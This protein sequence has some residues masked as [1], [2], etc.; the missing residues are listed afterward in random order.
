MCIRDRNSSALLAIIATCLGAVLAKVQV[1]N[2]IVETV[3]AKVKS[4]FGL[5]TSVVAVTAM[6]DACTS[7]TFLAML[8]ACEFFREK[9]H[10]AG[11]SDSD[12]VAS[13]MSVGSQFIAI[14][15]WADTAIYMAGI[16]GVATFASLP[17]TFFC[18]GCAVMMILLSIPGIGF[19]VAEGA[20]AVSYT[21]LDVYKRQL[22]KC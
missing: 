5:T 15:P 6:M 14:V 13:A 18:W 22:Q 9:F 10:L 11:L 2:V 4:R 8:L 16:T 12:L 21:H 3:F 1:V 7:S 20:A 17:Y 19:F